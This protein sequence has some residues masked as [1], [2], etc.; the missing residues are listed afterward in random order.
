MRCTQQN[1][2][3]NDSRISKPNGKRISTLRDGDVSN[4]INENRYDIQNEKPSHHFKTD[5]TFRFVKRNGSNHCVYNRRHYG[6][7]VYESSHSK[8]F[9]KVVME[10]V[11][12]SLPL[13]ISTTI[14]TT[15]SKRKMDATAR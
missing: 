15:I 9:K 7:G 5:L 2:A 6:K 4:A 14:F 3:R 12:Q 13:K 11:L 1:N 10:C 8:V